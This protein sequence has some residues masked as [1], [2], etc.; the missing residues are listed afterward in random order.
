MK[1]A[2]NGHTVWLDMPVSA[3]K[4]WDY[5]PETR[6]VMVIAVIPMSAQHRRI[7]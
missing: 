2:A 3:L 1:S 6:P 5:R 7:Q 4:R